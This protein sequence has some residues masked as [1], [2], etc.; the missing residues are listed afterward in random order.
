MQIDN[1]R[2]ARQIMIKEI[3]EKGQE[4]LAL[5]RVFVA[6][7]GGLGSPILTYLAA[8][9]IG[10]LTILDGD[11]VSISNLNRQFLHFYKDIGREKTVSAAEKL[12]A[13]YPQL[14]IKP[15][16]EYLTKDNAAELIDGHDLVVVAL[17][18]MESRYVLNDA[19]HEKN[20]V[21]IEGAATGFS[22]TLTK[23]IPGKTPCYRCI[24]PERAEKPTPAKGVVGAI[25]GVIGSLE[26]LEAVK[27]IVGM[28]SALIGK[29]LYFNGRDMSFNTLELPNIGCD[30]CK[31]YRV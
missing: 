10:H 19:C 8:A 16:T 5:A 23:I 30:F 27:H 9:G 17:D 26:A 11:T 13:F 22:G 4:K 1:E 28:P 29:I 25:P 14:D 12:T 24:Y 20:I 2:F 3:G 18:N 31:K 6:G 15:C 7:A 21:M